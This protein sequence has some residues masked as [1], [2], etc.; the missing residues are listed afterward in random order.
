M[1]EVTVEECPICWRS[2]SI[3]LVPVAIVCGHSFCHDCSN[4]LRKCP[5]CRKKLSSNYTRVTNYSLLSLVS[6][7]ESV[8]KKETRDQE[9]QTE[10]PK[11]NYVRRHETNAST[12]GKALQ[13][14]YSI[15]QKLTRL[16]H[17]LIRQL[18]LNSNPI[19]N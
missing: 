2:F 12:E 8:G 17:M 16:Q 5:L 18:K 3:T 19:P 14:T 4:D 1:S 10:Q 15:I 6:R 13:N 11:R 9:I 7:M